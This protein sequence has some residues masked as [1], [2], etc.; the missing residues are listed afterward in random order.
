M[1]LMAFT[2]SIQANNSSET[3][4]NKSSGSLKQIDNILIGGINLDKSILIDLGETIPKGSSN[5]T[6]AI[7]TCII[8]ASQSKTNFIKNVVVGRTTNFLN[9][10]LVLT[11]SCDIRYVLLKPYSPMD[12]SIEIDAIRKTTPHY[13]YTEEKKPII[14][15]P[16]TEGKKYNSPNSIYDRLW[17][18][19]F[20]CI[21]R[22]FI[23]VSTQKENYEPK[24][25]TP[26]FHWT[27]THR[28]TT[29][30]STNKS[31]KLNFGSPVFWIEIR[32][33]PD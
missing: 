2:N 12:D 30:L 20:Q 6:D 1:I 7:T 10:C 5:R 13:D 25:V 24:S 21:S 33:P 17:R 15:S 23:S 19:G 11:A 18:V 28:N 26:N 9:H 22:N 29:P 27:K 32:P 8:R 16:E 31:Q 14:V 4:Y 3:S